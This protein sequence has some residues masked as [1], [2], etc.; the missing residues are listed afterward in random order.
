MTQKPSEICKTIKTQSIMIFTENQKNEIREALERMEIAGYTALPII[1]K[2][3][4]RYRGTLTEG[5]L[6]WALKNL[7]NMDLKEAERRNIMEIAHKRD[8][9]PVTV[10]TDV[11]DL[12][13]KAMDQN[14]VPVVD[15]R[16]SFIGI[17][18]R[19]AIMRHYITRLVMEKHAR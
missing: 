10:S 19:K 16:G 17:V 2:E 15:D 3:N 1:D 13:A 6:L 7:C 8:N 9:I 5:D 11:Q 18:T 12:L 14:F 4:G